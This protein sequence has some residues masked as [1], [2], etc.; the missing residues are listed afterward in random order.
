VDKLTTTLS[1]S[2]NPTVQ[3]RHSARQVVELTTTLSISHSPTVQSTL[4]TQVVLAVK[5]KRKNVF[6]RHWSSLV[7]S[8]GVNSSW[9]C[10]MWISAAIPTVY[11]LTQ[12]LQVNI[13]ML[14]WIW[15]RPF[16]STCS[17]N[18]NLLSSTYS[19]LCRHSY[20]KRL[21]INRDKKVCC[22]VISV[23]SSLYLYF[24]LFSAM[25]RRYCTQ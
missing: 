6:W 17:L 7:I 13:E 15:Q 23:S 3:S 9:R 25:G 12:S 2:Y 20:W 21:S 14:P 18:C 19:T 22:L 16:P 4:L 8:S 24:I 11:G 5:C 10:L 1:I